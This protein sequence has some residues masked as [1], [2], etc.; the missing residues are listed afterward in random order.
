MSKN[1][2]YPI[3]LKVHQLNVLLVGG[4]FVGTEKLSFLL[5]SSPKAQVTA[6]SKEFNAEFL[7]LAG[8]AANVTLIQDAYD[9]KYLGG[10][11]LVIAATNIPEINKQIHDEAKERYILVNVADTPELCDF[12]LGGIVTKGNLKIAISTN[13]KS[14]TTAKRLRQMLEEVLPEEIDELLENLNAYRD[15]LKGDFEYKVKAMNEI[16]GMLVEKKG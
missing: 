14:P 16:T 6:V 8:Q 13:G 11:H 10:K 5:K 15:T 12:Y 4:G 1:P 7:E 9:E 3:F 2:L